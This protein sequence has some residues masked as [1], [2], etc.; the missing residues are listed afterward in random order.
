MKSEPR[1]IVAPNTVI[2]NTPADIQQQS[3]YGA[4]GG[5]QN[6]SGQQ[7]QSLALAEED[8]M[9]YGQD[10]SYDDYGQYG[11]QSG[12]DGQLID[13]SMTAGADGNKGKALSCFLT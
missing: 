10:E 7:Q 13:P 6:S 12:Y 3:V 11:D 2:A 9:S 1:D 8:D 5:Q 4:G